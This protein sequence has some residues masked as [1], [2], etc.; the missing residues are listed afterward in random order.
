MSL[1]SRP[2]RSQQIILA[3]FA[4]VITSGFL[5]WIPGHRVLGGFLFTLSILGVLG[6]LAFLLIRPLA[7]RL[8]W[9]VRHRLFVTYL[10][11]GA[12]PV[13]L[14]FQL[15]YL[16]FHLVINQTA[17]YMLH[18]EL[19][20]HLEQLQTSAERLALD[21]ASARRPTESM[22]RDE[23]AVIRNGNRVSFFPETAT[24]ETGP[25]TEFPAWSPTGFKGIIRNKAGTH[26]FATHATA[27][28]GAHQV[29]VFIV[30][31][32]DDKMLAQLLRGVASVR[33]IAGENLSFRIGSRG[34]GAGTQILLDSE[35]AAPGP[36]RRGFWD[37]DLEIGS[38]L[39]VRSMETGKTEAETIIIDSYPSAILTRLFS[40]LGNNAVLP[41]IL[42]LI[43][44]A[45]FLLVEL[46]ALVSMVQLTRTIT[47]SVHDLH[48][49]TKK[50][51]AGDF[52]H[53]IAI[54]SREQLSELAESFNS[55]TQR[56]EQLI[57]EVKEK[58]KLESELE[59]ARQVQAQL[60]PK[61]I[62]KLATL[63][64][65]GV[66]NPARVVSGDYYDFIRIDAHRT[67]LVIGDISGKGISAALLMASVQSSLH[68]QLA[69]KTD[70]PVSTAALV[71]RLNR[72]LYEN[73]PAEKYAT[74][75]CGIYDEQTSRLSYTNAGH[76]PP[77]LL[78]GGNAMRL[79]TRDTVVGMFPD[80]P[81]EEAVVELLPGDV[82]AAFT[83]GV[84]EPEDAHEEQFGDERL[85]ELLIQNSERP[86]EEIARIVMAAVHSWTHDL[87]NQDDITLLLA[88]RQEPHG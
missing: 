28:E 81:Y 9:R 52:S 14:L 23:E 49:G 43:V 7:R 25:I 46:G 58:E 33:I 6:L 35:K 56:I 47:G 59:I 38:P 44:G 24:P 80:S 87:S 68:A 32:L 36:Q 18:A 73:T 77:I 26:F 27:A 20:R 60:F 74:F 17:N 29:D 82:F 37:T 72:Q 75:Y 19:S 30:K 34:S 41:A 69:M 51:E 63:Q 53:R 12:V 1:L 79:E 83:D 22:S 48:V 15:G 57:V 84:T 4:V 31:T 40:T 16:G 21:V 67:A 45:A 54:R 3:L 61:Q 10:L 64:M 2:R 13:V 88:R 11:A 50:V 42:M 39:E 85:V 70:G 66:C 5:A 8:L 76:L 65:T 55:M 62:P 78:R 71:G 86:L